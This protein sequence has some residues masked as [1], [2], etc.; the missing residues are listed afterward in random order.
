MDVV[1]FRKMPILEFPPLLFEVLN[2]R[3]PENKNVLYFQTD[4]LLIEA[5]EDMPTDVDGECGVKLPLE[6]SMLKQRLDIFVDSYTWK[7][8]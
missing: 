8:D 5:D 1:A 2:G 7:F 4:S 3:H 6:F